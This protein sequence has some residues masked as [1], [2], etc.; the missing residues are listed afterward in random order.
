MEVLDWE[1]KIVESA[2][3]SPQARRVRIVEFM[4]GDPPSVARARC[5]VR[6]G[7]RVMANMVDIAK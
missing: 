2:A 1:E 7:G 6:D 3:V 4:V 5:R